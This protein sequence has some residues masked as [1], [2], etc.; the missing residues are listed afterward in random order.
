M[1]PGYLDNL[2]VIQNC[3]DHNFEIIKLVIKDAEY[4]FENKT[5]EIE[6]PPEEVKNIPP[7]QFDMDKVRTTI[8][9]FVRDW[10]ADGAAEREACYLP[11]VHE[12][13]D[14]FPKSKC[15]PSKISILV[16]GAGLGRLAYEIA[17]HGYS[18]QGNEWSLFMLMASNFIL[19]KCN[20]VN[21][22]TLYPWVHQWTNNVY[23]EDQ[24]AS[25]KFPDVNP[26]DLPPNANFSMA[27]GDF[28]E[29]YT[30]PETFD[31]VATVFFIDTAHCIIS[32]IE[33]IYSILKP[34]GYW[35]NLGPL[36]YHYSDIPN[37]VSIELSYEEVKRVVKQVGFKIEKEE[38][39]VLST[40]TQNPKSM[41]KYEY[42]SVFF[43]A[44][45]P[46]S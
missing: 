38:M 22:F 34:G 46:C 41:L 32:Y 20:S 2:T 7:T 33:A 13:C 24:T 21:A 9:Q 4:M 18:C 27:A 8:K 19:N 11:V 37:E 44:Q 42:N 6:N 12:I 25:C 23:T 14:K 30:E 1:I 16:P 5:H 28:L 3:V 35:I 36:L 10:S 29:I 39:D 26:A 17:K 15:D 43:T 45:K 40:Y 31:C